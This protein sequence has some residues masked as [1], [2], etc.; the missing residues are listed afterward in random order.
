MKTY[1]FVSLA[2]AAA[3]VTDAIKFVSGPEGW[4]E[5]LNFNITQTVYP[6]RLRTRAVVP[7]K[8]ELKNRNPHIPGAKTTKIRY[9][10]YRVPGASR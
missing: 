10:P 8:Q 4:S 3:G 9:G 2:L 7:D 1:T 6:R 5:S